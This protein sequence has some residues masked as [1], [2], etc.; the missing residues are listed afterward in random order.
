M[1]VSLTAESIKAA[2]RRY[3]AESLFLGSAAEAITDE[4]SLL[5]SQ[6]LD[7]TGVLELVEFIEASFGVTVKDEEMLPENLDSL[8]AIARFVLARKAAT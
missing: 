8:G 1:S 3:V 6:V 7:S 2:V 4:Q 5:S